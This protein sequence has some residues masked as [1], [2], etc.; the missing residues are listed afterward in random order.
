MTEEDKTCIQHL[1]LTVPSDDKKRIENTKGDLL[2][3]SCCWIFDNAEFRQWRDDEQSRLLWIK[4]DPGKGKTMLLC[5][6]VNDLQKSK[7]DMNLLAYFF[8]QATDW[9]VNSAVAVLRGLM[10]LLVTWQPSLVSYIRKKYDLA[11]KALFEDTNSW[12]ALTEIFT[13]ILQ[14]RNLKSTYLV[15]D[16]L[17]ECVTDLPQLLKL[18]AKQSSI[19]SC[20]K[21]IVSSRNRPG[22]EKTLE[23]VGY[24][25]RLCLE[26]NAESV[27]AAVS[28][29]IE[30]KVSQL[31]QENRY[32]RQIQDTVKEHRMRT[33]C[34]FG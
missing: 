22:I 13:D 32:D 23:Q 8:C 31:A 17:D 26:L 14:G 15:I 7:T 20:V 6:I 18:I 11:G 4:G 16:A 25:V 2:V 28:I 12:I 19:R 1:R 27:S 33:I 21:W 10:Y 3:D 9:R 34:S 29:F 5:G 30:K 24:K